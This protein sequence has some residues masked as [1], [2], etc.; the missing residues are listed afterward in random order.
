M[1]ELDEDE[2]DALKELFNIGVGCAAHSLSEMVQD[3]VFL[4]IPY[5]EITSRQQAIE[6]ILE[7]A[8][9]QIAA[10]KQQ[11]HGH[12]SGT[13]FLVYPESS[14]L[15]LVRSLIGEDVPLESLTELEQESLLEV[16][17]I[18]LNACLG[19]FANMMTLE[20]DFDLPEYIKGSCRSLFRKQPKGSEK[21]DQKDRTEQKIVFLILDF[22]T[23]EK[24]KKTNSIKGFVMILL[25]T[26]AL[27]NLKEKLKQLLH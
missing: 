25:D 3:E 17:N 24:T 23:G 22:M 27:F 6:L 26:E 19:S 8:T 12:F 18:I 21:S 11:F 9:N 1:L 7:R 2:I 4:S 5:L 10:I 16:G 20:L 13:A 14:S 15:E